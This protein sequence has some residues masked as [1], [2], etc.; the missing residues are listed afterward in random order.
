MTPSIVKTTI[1]HIRRGERERQGPREVKVRKRK[2]RERETERES[3]LS[4]GA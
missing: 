4:N 1:N 3:K 2:E